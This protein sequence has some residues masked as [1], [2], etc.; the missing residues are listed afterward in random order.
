MRECVELFTA[1]NS[2]AS[3]IWLC[4]D[5]INVFCSLMQTGKFVSDNVEDQTEQVQQNQSFVLALQYFFL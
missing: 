1:T 4:C 3:F 5:D 2:N